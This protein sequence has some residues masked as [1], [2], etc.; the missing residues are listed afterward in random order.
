MNDYFGCDY[1][2]RF[3]DYFLEPWS[4]GPIFKEIEDVVVQRGVLYLRDMVKETQLSHFNEDCNLLGKQLGSKEVIKA[5]PFTAN[6]K[7]VHE[8]LRI[9]LKKLKHNGLRGML[10]SHLYEI[11]A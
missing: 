9:K 1:T 4:K 6:L 10:M 3:F 11:L 8:S 7:K 5:I 2:K